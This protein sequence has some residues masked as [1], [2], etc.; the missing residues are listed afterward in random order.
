[1]AASAPLGSSFIGRCQSLQGHRIHQVVADDD[2]SS[3]AGRIDRK[4]IL[5]R[6]TSFV[7]KPMAKKASVVS[8]QMPPEAAQQLMRAGGTVPRFEAYPGGGLDCSPVE[9]TPR[10]VGSGQG[11]GGYAPFACMTPR[12]M[13]ATGSTCSSPAVSMDFSPAVSDPSWPSVSPGLGSLNALG[14]ADGEGQPRPR[15]VFMLYA[16]PM[17]HDPIDFRSEAEVL[18]QAF[19]E[20][21]SDVRLKMGVA[22][23]GSLTK[24]LALARSRRGLVLH[25]SAHAT[26]HPEK[27]I[28]LVLEDAH[29]GPHILWRDKL[30]EFLNASGGLRH[31]SMLFLSTCYSEE[32]AQIFIE[33]GCH[34]V[35]ATRT[36]VWDS[37]ARRFAQHLYYE[38]GVNNNLLKAWE[39]SVQALRID[40]DERM[41]KEAE[42]FSFFGQRGAERATLESLC[43]LD[44]GTNASIGSGLSM[45]DF[46]NA[47]TFLDMHLKAETE[48]C[49]GRQSYLNQLA[50]IFCG[51]KGRRAVLF[52]GPRGIGKSMFATEFAHFATAPGRLFSCSPLLLKIMRPDLLWTLLAL[53]EQLDALCANLALASVPRAGRPAFAHPRA[54]SD[55]SVSSYDK[56][57]RSDSS[58]CSDGLSEITDVDALAHARSRILRTIRDLE[59]SHR[60]A[61]LLIVIDDEAGYLKSSMD[62]RKLLGDL[63]EQTH[64]LHVLITSREPVYDPL[65]S[66]RIVNEKLPPLTDLDAARLFSQRIHRRLEPAELGSWHHA[67]GNHPPD[68]GKPTEMAIEATRDQVIAHLR[69]HPLLQRLAGHPGNIVS[70]ASRVV[71]GGPSLFTLAAQEDLLDELEDASPLVRRN[72]TVPERL[73]VEIAERPL[74]PYSA[75]VLQD[76]IERDDSIDLR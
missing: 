48:T 8:F 30:E 46:A 61:Q 49:I 39:G 5:K 13:G 75:S 16:S 18:S 1:M 66:T 56:W 3:S 11:L 4:S 23:A 71:P 42:S 74:R 10:S 67:P 29:G 37:T 60:C 20:S 68:P 6:V 25:L 64:H 58:G 72:T 15:E 33:H 52:H 2:E 26:K 27:G 50:R 57:S 34:H 44:A 47:A 17:F 76:R 69:G 38:L 62:A 51:P 28:G 53:E 14:V 22:T 19:N 24:L 65:G 63:L 40:P 36:K 12:S 43:G 21:G 73:G 31:I 45:R 32:L 9:S 70:T 55:L 41:A 35:L 7:R 59:R 54:P